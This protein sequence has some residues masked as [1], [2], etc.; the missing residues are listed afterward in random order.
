MRF[1]DGFWLLK[2]GVKAYFGLQ[3]VK[4]EEGQ[5]VAEADILAFLELFDLVANSTAE[6]ALNCVFAKRMDLLDG[7]QFGDE[8]RLENSLPVVTALAFRI[9]TAYN[10]LLLELQDEEE[11]LLLRGEIPEEREE[12]RMEREFVIG[13]LLRLAVNLDYADEI[14][15]RKMF[16]LVR[17]MISQNILPEGLVARCLDV[18]RKLSPNE[19]D[20][21]RVVV[22]VVHE[23]RD[24]SEEDEVAKD[25]SGADD[26]AASIPETPM[27][28]KT[29]RPAQKPEEE[30]SPE[31]QARADAVD[32]RCLSLCIG[33]LERVNG[34]FE[35]NSTLE[36]LLGELIIPAVKRKEIA[37][38]EKGLISL[39]LCCLIARRMALN[40]FQLF[41][42]Q[43]QAAP[44]ILRMRVLQIIF[45]LLMVHDKDFLAPNNETGQ[46]IVE[47]LLLILDNEESPKVQAL[48]CMGLAKLML[49]GMVVDDRVLQSLVL[50][51]VSPETAQNQELRQCLTYFFPVYCYSSPANQRRMQQSFVTLFLKL[52]EVYKEWEGDEDMISPAQTGL[53]VVDWTDPQKAAAIA[54]KV[55]GYVADD[56]IHVD[57][58]TDIVKTL[59]NDDLKRDDKKI[60]CQLLGKLYMP[61][62]IDDD[63][64]RSLKLLMHNLRARRPLR[65][66]TSKNA[67]AKFENAIA[68]KYEQQL[69]DF[70]EEEYRQLEHLKDLFEFLDEIIPEEDDDEDAIPVRR[71]GRKRRSGSVTSDT[72][73]TTSFSGDEQATPPRKSNGKGK[74]KR[75]RLSESD[76]EDEDDAS[77]QRGTPST[78]RAPTRVMPRRSAADK[79]REAM[80]KSLA[81]PTPSDEE[82]EE[83]GSDDD[84]ENEVEA[85]PVAP[86]G[87]ASHAPSRKG[88]RRE[89]D[90]QTPNP[91]DSILGEVSFDSI[92]DDSDEND[93]EELSTLIFALFSLSVAKIPKTRGPAAIPLRPGSPA[94]TITNSSTAPERLSF[95]PHVSR[96]KPPF[97]ARVPVRAV[98]FRFKGCG[99]M[100]EWQSPEVLSFCLFLYGQITVFFLGVFLWHLILTSRHVEFG[101]VTGHLRFRLA[102][103]PYLIS[104]YSQLATLILLS[105]TL[106]RSGGPSTCGHIPIL[107]SLAC[108]G[109]LAVATASGNLGIRALTIWRRHRYVQGAIAALC[110]SHVVFAILLGAFGVRAGW[111]AG[112][113]VCTVI[114]EVREGLFSFFLSTIGLDLSI[115]LFTIVGL[116]TQERNRADISRIWSTLFTQGIAYATLTCIT[117]VPMA[118]FT[119]LDLNFAMNMI[120]VVPGSTISV[121]AS[122]AVVTSLLK[123]GDSPVRKVSTVHYDRL[124]HNDSA[125]KSYASSNQLSTHIS[126]SSLEYAN[127]CDVSDSRF[128]IDVVG[129]SSS[130]VTTGKDQR[131]YISGGDS[132]FDSN[133]SSTSGILW[134]LGYCSGKS[135]SVYPPQRLSIPIRPRCMVQWSG[136]SASYCIPRTAPRSF[137]FN[138]EEHTHTERVDQF[139]IVLA[140]SRQER[141]SWDFST[142]QVTNSLATNGLPSLFFLHLRPA[143]PAQDSSALTSRL[144]MKA[145]FA[146]LA[147][148]APLVAAHYTFPDFISGGTTSG[149]WVYVRK[150]ANYESQNPVTDVTS[151]EFRCY[152]LDLPPFVA[153]NTLYH[154][155]YLD[156]YMSKAS[157]AANSESAGSGQTW[158][159]VYE[160]PPVYSNGQLS[161]PSETLSSFT[162]TLPASI[163]SGQYLVRAE[164]IAIH[165]ASTYGGAQFYIGCA[166]I[167]VVNG[168]S[169]NPGPLVSIPGVYTGYEP[170][171]L[172]NIYELPKN[173]TSY[174]SPGP[175]VWRG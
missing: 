153:D 1:N 157:P 109:N 7:L 94:T 123:F 55:P 160:L 142:L 24:N 33:M 95:S 82:E 12:S 133:A 122:S 103:A 168:G 44:E 18:L 74:A 40:S 86:R 28:E 117:G 130:S 131:I 173:F 119:H 64:I 175:A 68:K 58:A 46:R 56:A 139:T 6:D 75:R 17:D 127:S 105:V 84:D 38:R 164:H 129:Q 143:E 14:G 39:G 162:F 111:N 20:L 172:I 42:G 3:V 21:I 159:K 146:I 165:A 30:K 76:D 96:L 89:S 163:P 98:S 52:A 87:K 54:Q 132:M 161:F 136:C 47:F 26:T 174:P 4:P 120:V 101:L 71:T 77:T 112:H 57:L 22:E 141:N 100:V 79:S 45:D 67:F 155:G 102:H 110:V 104:R 50:V 118:I 151:D 113:T 41:M 88:N 5:S 91:E 49:A 114:D 16:Q 97:A 51:Y 15:R 128:D 8:A 154:P 144:K 65:D 2:S 116:L 150:T 171:I 13:E 147:T 59:F 32:M 36:G 106:S 62:K 134:F 11:E 66:S 158:F 23:L 35:E 60:L 25:I 145:F 70:N 61:D 43:I 81:V 29:V 83:A 80:S 37:I 121:M 85:T 156:V 125:A 138:S 137:D 107:R 99:Q 152:E 78:A 53:M 166:Q 48:L 135:A 140:T 108:L 63:K 34:T 170:G 169:G 148:L 126:L 19:R 27:T 72:T 10:D 124:P 167:N 90:S 115:L 73:T 31:E 92:M 149:D 9:Q 69:A 93:D